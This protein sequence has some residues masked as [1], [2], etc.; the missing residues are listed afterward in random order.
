MS[1]LLCW[2]KTTARSRAM[3]VE[4]LFLGLAKVDSTTENCGALFLELIF[5]AVLCVV[6]CCGSCGCL[7]EDEMKRNETC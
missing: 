5:E 1:T 3:W 4:V 7:V 6:F 2:R